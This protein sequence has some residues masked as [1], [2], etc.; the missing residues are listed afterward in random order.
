MYYVIALVTAATAIWL[1][2]YMA[3]VR[4][5]QGAAWDQGACMFTAAIA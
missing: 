5:L 4:L 1:Y 2:D 3:D